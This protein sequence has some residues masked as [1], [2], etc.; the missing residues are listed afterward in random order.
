M[1]CFESIDVPAVVY[2]MTDR[3]NLSAILSDGKI[4]SKEDFMTFF[5][6]SLESIPVYIAATGADACRLYYGADGRVHQAPPLNHAET[7][8]LKLVPRYNNGDWFVES[9]LAGVQNVSNPTARALREKLCRLMDA[10]R[11]CHYGPMRFKRDPE[12]IELTEIDAMPEPKEVEEIRQAQERFNSLPEQ[13]K[14]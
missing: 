4:D 12:I 11:V 8:V 6:P 1:C 7:V 5:F 3:K 9:T 13:D 2:H 10:A 14:L